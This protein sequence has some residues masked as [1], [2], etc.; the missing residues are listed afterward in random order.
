MIYKKQKEIV[1]F[2]D[3]LRKFFLNTK[4]EK[5]QKEC[6]KTKYGFDD[7]PY[8][9]DDGKCTINSLSNQYYIAICWVT[10]I[11]T[12][13]KCVVYDFEYGSIMGSEH[14]L[15]KKQIIFEEFLELW[16]DGKI[17]ELGNG[18]EDYFI[19]AHKNSEFYKYMINRIRNKVGVLRSYETESYIS[20][21]PD[22]SCGKLRV[23][24]KVISLN[25]VW[26]E[27]RR[28]E[29]RTLEYQKF[30]YLT[31]RHRANHE[32]IQWEVGKNMTNYEN[33]KN[34]TGIEE[35]V[36]IEA[37]GMLLAKIH[38]DVEH[39]IFENN[40]DKYLMLYKAQKEW[41]EREH[42]TK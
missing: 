22:R 5:N 30:R 15:E 37:V 9:Y 38:D 13:P 20:C 16:G 21:W 33:L 6:A 4:D 39:G 26:K 14:F 23:V 17:L 25:E 24:N 2:I 3:A 10:T 42:D 40:Y 8:V 18:L 27:E 35:P 32:L 7:S 28:W 12:F 1:M 31:E 36:E 19:Q 41:L 11:I 29:R 34:I